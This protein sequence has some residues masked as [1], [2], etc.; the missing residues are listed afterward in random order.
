MELASMA[1]ALERQDDERNRLYAQLQ[2]GPN[3]LSFIRTI[4]RAALCKL[5]DFTPQGV[6]ML[7]ML[8]KMAPPHFSIDDS[9]FAELSEG[10]C[11]CINA[12]M[13]KGTQLSGYDLANTAWALSVMKV[14]DAG[15]LNAIESEATKKLDTMEPRHLSMLSLA[16]ARMGFP[17][18]LFFGRLV[19]LLANNLRKLSV[20]QLGGIMWAV[21][22]TD[23]R[24]RPF[25]E[26]CREFVQEQIQR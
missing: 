22:C 8:F 2:S 23:V 6:G 5:N 11:A 26:S 12:Y 17:A 20:Q 13:M 3:G 4:A 24:Y 14:H 9:M 7:A 21:T 18:N 16:F 25:L 15:I 19:R 10:I 1:W